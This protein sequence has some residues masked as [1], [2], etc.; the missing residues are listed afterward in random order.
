MA[1]GRRGPGRPQLSRSMPPPPL[2]ATNVAQSSG[3]NVQTTSIRHRGNN[4]SSGSGVLHT[5]LIPIA[6]IHH[7]AFPPLPPNSNFTFELSVVMY[8]LT[9][10]CMQYMNIYKTTWWLPSYPATYSL[11]FYLV[12]PY[13]FFFIVMILVRRLAWCFVRDIYSNVQT[14]T[15]FYIMVLVFKVL[16]M[17]TMVLTMVWCLW[18][19]V[20]YNSP[21]NLLFLAYPLVSYL[22]LYGLT[23]EVNANLVPL[24]TSKPKTEPPHPTQGIPWNG[25]PTWFPRHKCSDSPQD[26]RFEADTLKVD[27]N[28]RMKTV[29]FNSMVCAY[30]VG[31]VPIC[32]LQPHMYLDLWWSCLL[33][34]FVWINSFVMFGAHFLPPR[35]CDTLH[36]CSLHLGR[37]Q[38]VEHSYNS[39]QHFWSE[40]TVWPQGVLVRYNKAL[41]KA[42]GVQNVALPSDSSYARFYF[43]FHQPMRL[44]YL[45]LV[46]ELMVVLIELY[47]LLTNTHWNYVVSLSLMLFCNYY[48]LFKLLRDR[49]V[50]IRVYHQLNEDGD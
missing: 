26:V 40:T 19:M 5:T 44:L 23:I 47:I 41:Y 50:L 22:L 42:T 1:G 25:S 4:S 3:N 20:Q 49:W 32:F 31:F 8:L 21:L 48:S 18:K 35:Y 33:I 14:V 45:F 28:A 24:A 27:F 39:P 15:L 36:R 12:D 9:A 34:A 16:L 2:H 11:N 17:I 10:L 37:W 7:P 38:R 46:L 13:L 30:Y 43:M 6:P 29:L